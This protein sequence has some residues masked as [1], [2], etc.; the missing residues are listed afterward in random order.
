M[1]IYLQ[2]QKGRNML[3]EVNDQNFENEVLKSELPVVVDFWAAWCGP[4]RVLSPTVDK[5]SEEYK[6]KIKFCKL[7]VDENAQTAIQY[8]VMS[9]PTLVF[10]KGGQKIDSIRGA[11]PETIIKPKIETLLK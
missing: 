4:C 2:K 10:F 7:N 11:V 3:L 5:I 6:G 1:I 9:I 8:E